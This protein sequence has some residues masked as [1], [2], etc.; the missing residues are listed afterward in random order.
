[1]P[2]QSSTE[3]TVDVPPES[4]RLLRELH[5][6]AEECAK[7][8]WDGANAYPV[9]EETCR[10]ATQV[11]QGL[12][13]EF[14]PPSAGAEPD[15]QLTLDWYREPRRT[16]SLSISPDG[17]LHYAALIGRGK[18][19]GTEPFFG[20]FPLVIVDVLRRVYAA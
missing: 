20:E 4:A 15:G 6:I 13:A 17:E 18:V 19:A 8:N 10:L 9:T 3:G 7:P 14:P 2:D 5:Q 12:P 1:M 11:V 16:L